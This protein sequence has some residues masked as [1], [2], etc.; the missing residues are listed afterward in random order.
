MCVGKAYA[1]PDGPELRR[2]LVDAQRER[3]VRAADATRRDAQ[4]RLRDGGARRPAGGGRR[5]P[6][7]LCAGP[8]GG[9]GAGL[10]LQERRE[11]EI[12]QWKR[13]FAFSAIFSVP[14]FVVSMVLGMIIGVEW[15]QQE[16]FAGLTWEE[17]ITWALATPVQ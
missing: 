13:E 2:L 7:E 3:G 14:L 10:S 1:R 4:P 9:G 6:C 17:V 16:S 8:I 15:L 12:A 11:R 5:G